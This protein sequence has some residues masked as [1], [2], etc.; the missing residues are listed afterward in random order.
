MPGTGGDRLV[1]EMAPESRS[2]RMKASA[3]FVGRDVAAAF[4][5]IAPALATIKAAS[6]V[7]LMQGAIDSGLSSQVKVIQ[8]AIGKAGFASQFKAF[9]GSIRGRPNCFAIQDA[10]GGGRKNRDRSRCP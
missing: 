8:D 10:P 9:R 2:N 6:Q 4:E 3:A 7:Q 5:G 1:G